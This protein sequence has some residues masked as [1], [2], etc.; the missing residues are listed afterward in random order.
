[1]KIIRPSFEILCIT[2]TNP[3]QL[4]EVAGRTYYK[5]ENRITAESAEKFCSKI[6]MNQSNNDPS[7]TTHYSSV[8]SRTNRT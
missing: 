6:N 5:S 2:P 1:M 3:L 4:L 8:S 7:Y